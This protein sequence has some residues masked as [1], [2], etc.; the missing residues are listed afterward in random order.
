MYFWFSEEF[1]SEILKYGM[2]PELVNSSAFGVFPENKVPRLSNRTHFHFSGIS[3]GTS[4]GASPICSTSSSSS[5]CGTSFPLIEDWSSC[6]SREAPS[7]ETS[8]IDFEWYRFW[9]KDF[10]VFQLC[11]FARQGEVAPQGHFWQ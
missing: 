11:V 8:S 7:W 3:K 1:I 5:S 2:F 4:S 6:F 10:L 9:Q